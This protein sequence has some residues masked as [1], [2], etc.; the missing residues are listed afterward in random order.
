MR[1]SYGEEKEEKFSRA[2]SKVFLAGPPFLP[3][4]IRPKRLGF[5]CN[6]ETH[7]NKAFG[8]LGISAKHH[9]LLL[10]SFEGMASLQSLP[11][12]LLPQLSWKGPV[13]RTAIRASLEKG[14]KGSHPNSVK[15]IDVRMDLES[16]PVSILVK[17][18]NT[19]QLSEI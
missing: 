5:P 13:G 4:A 2:L 16:V 14:N 17:F 12:F 6:V 11:R 7:A 18:S 8:R 19:D 3:Q 9:T 1:C 10:C 15:Q